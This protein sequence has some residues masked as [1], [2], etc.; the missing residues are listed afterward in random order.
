M[1]KSALLIIISLVT[2]SCVVI[3]PYLGTSY[4]YKN[5]TAYWTEYNVL[6]IDNANYFSYIQYN[7]SGT[8][9][10]GVEGEYSIK[11][12]SLILE[13]TDPVE[14]I[15]QKTSI[16]YSNFG[17]PDSVYFMFYD[18][19]PKV[20]EV[21]RYRYQ[22]VS[23]SLIY[24]CQKDTCPANQAIDSKVW[25]G[26]DFNDTIKVPR[27]Y[28]NLIHIDTLDLFD[29][30]DDLMDKKIPIKVDEYNCIKIFVAL[31][32]K[33]DLIEIP[34]RFT[35]VGK[36]LITDFKNKKIQFKLLHKAGVSLD[37]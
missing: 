22:K 31:K 4:I 25:S 5:K 21:N 37:K 16:K 24:D 23:S 3:N 15:V 7:K 12:D 32:P 1:K 19:P 33:F 6:A 10:E 27:N 28:Y 26:W 18:L 13:I 11:N 34:T 8:L 2:N 36:R 29:P 35:I 20:L 9:N 30:N 17:S 14:Y